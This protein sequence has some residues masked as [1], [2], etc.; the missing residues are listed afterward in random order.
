MSFCDAK[1]SHTATTTT[2]PNQV[3]AAK[4]ITWQGAAAE[5]LQRLIPASEPVLAGTVP[6]VFAPQAAAC[7]SADTMAVS[8]H[9]FTA[10][11]QRCRTH[12]DRRDTAMGL[13]GMGLSLICRILSLAPIS[14]QGMLSA[15]EHLSERS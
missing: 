8:H 11:A 14:S 5:M 10:K 4:V 7:A 1:S 6:A 13:A 3:P 9:P 2:Q 15:R 12:T